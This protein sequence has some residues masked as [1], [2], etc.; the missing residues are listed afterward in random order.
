[1]GSVMLFCLPLARNDN[2]Y[3]LQNS[4]KM[5]LHAN[6]EMCISK[7]DVT[8]IFYKKAKALCKQKRPVSIHTEKLTF[9]YEFFPTGL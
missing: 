1:M 9:H 8:A 7:T 6:M 5:T 4:Q 2:L 3:F